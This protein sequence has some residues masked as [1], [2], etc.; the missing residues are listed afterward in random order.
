MLLQASTRNVDRKG[1]NVI[2]AACACDV[3]WCP[4]QRKKVYTTHLVHVRSAKWRWSQRA[5]DDVR[6]PRTR[7][8]YG[9]D[10]YLKTVLINVTLPCS[11]RPM[12]CLLY[13][14]MYRPSSMPSVRE[15]GMPP[16]QAR[17]GK[18]LVSAPQRPR[19]LA[20]EGSTGFAAQVSESW[21]PFRCRSLC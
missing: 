6:Q 18:S 20:L 9:W 7:P 1:E 2:L 21:H 3:A 12:L 4:S 14:S 15:R 13:R 16:G 5:L 17:W 10:I 8:I 19:S 11:Q